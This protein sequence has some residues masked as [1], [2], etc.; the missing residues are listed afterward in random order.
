MSPSS[1]NL[2]DIG[3]AT[4]GIAA[5]A[6]ACGGP[7]NVPLGEL[8]VEAKAPQQSVPTATIPENWRRPTVPLPGGSRAEVVV[9]PTPAAT[10]PSLVLFAVDPTPTATATRT[11]EKAV[12]QTAT[13]IEYTSLAEA[14]G[15]QQIPD[16]PEDARAKETTALK[17]YLAEHAQENFPTSLHPYGMVAKVGGES[18]NW[19][20]LES[21]TEGS[22]FK[23][24]L[25][26]NGAVYSLTDVVPGEKQWGPVVDKSGDIQF[27][28][29]DGA[30]KW[31]Y[32]YPR[33][34]AEKVGATQPG[35]GVA[36]TKPA[37]P[38][39]EQ[40][41]VVKAEWAS[42]SNVRVGGWESG[43]GKTESLYVPGQLFGGAVGS[44][45]HPHK[46]MGG[47][48]AIT[49]ISQG[50]RQEGDYVVLTLNISGRDNVT[51]QGEGTKLEV[52]LKKGSTAVY[53]MLKDDPACADSGARACNINTIVGPDGKSIG[54]LANPEEA[55]Q[56]GRFVG[57]NL[58]QIVRPGAI[59][60][61]FQSS[62]I[63][64]F[65]AKNLEFVK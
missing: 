25:W 21:A 51:V 30:G 2:K 33:A 13:L 40:A 58:E 16:I 62:S 55:L 52:W 36:E 20:F 15:N 24:Y 18:Q 34:L 8:G 41:P 22:A 32:F 59:I 53:N 45:I 49:G 46:L 48:T 56:A 4:L 60:R 39:A 10:E 3:L 50:A 9:S 61:D 38:G 37:A 6:S 7:A 54:E 5:A 57:V 27:G 35:S 64:L 17:A 44:V 43:W 1:L 26:V 28:F 63:F 29:Q 19:I 47:I 14:L 31:A 65:G 11:P 12:V 42:T 23:L